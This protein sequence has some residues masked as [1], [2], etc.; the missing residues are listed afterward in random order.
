[1]IALRK[2][3]TVKNGLLKLGKKKDIGRLPMLLKIIAEIIVGHNRIINNRHLP[4]NL[5]PEERFKSHQ[6]THRAIHTTAAALL[7]LLLVLTL[8]SLMALL[9]A[10][11]NTTVASLMPR[12]HHTL[13]RGLTHPITSRSRRH[14]CTTGCQRHRPCKQGQNRNQQYYGI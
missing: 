11:V 2:I 4:G 7:L 13:F 14:L 3:L 6:A 9:S 5:P 12:S 10:P 8:L 1:M